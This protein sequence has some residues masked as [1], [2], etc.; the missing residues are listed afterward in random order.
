MSQC[1]RT[2]NAVRSRRSDRQANRSRREEMNLLPILLGAAA[3]VQQ[4]QAQVAQ[5]DDAVLIEAGRVL[6]S[7]GLMNDHMHET[8]EFMIGVRY[9]HFGWSGSDRHGSTALSDNDVHMVVHQAD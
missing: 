1:R 8:G 7:V 9:Q 3:S 5:H 6:P 4:P 2:A